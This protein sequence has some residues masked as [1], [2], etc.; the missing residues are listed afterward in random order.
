[1]SGPGF[2]PFHPADCG[3]RKCVLRRSGEALFREH[4]DN[5]PHR[6]TIKRSHRAEG[7]NFVD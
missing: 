4:H 3:C 1:M 7:R 2:K 6:G 5:G